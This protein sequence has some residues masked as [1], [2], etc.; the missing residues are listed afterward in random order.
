MKI[1]NIDD[2]IR[3]RGA[4]L[5][6]NLKIDDIDD[7]IVAQSEIIALNFEFKLSLNAYLKDLIASPVKSLAGVIHFNKKQSKLVSM[8]VV[9][10]IFLVDNWILINIYNSII[11][12]LLD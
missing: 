10:F 11:L 12:W 7:I 6:D 1:D 5:V 2:I 8:Y 4:V 9:L 3:Q